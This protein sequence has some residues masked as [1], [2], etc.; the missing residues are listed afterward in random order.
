MRCLQE[1]QTS[2]EKIEIDNFKP[3]LIKIMFTPLVLKS[4]L[5]SLYLYNTVD[6]DGQQHSTLVQLLEGHGKEH[7][8]SQT[9]HHH[10]EDT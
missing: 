2:L 3:D 9:Q 10:Q 6:D 8:P 7:R 4:R 1:N 5:K